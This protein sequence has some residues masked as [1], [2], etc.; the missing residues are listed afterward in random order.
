MCEALEVSASGYYAW[1]ARPDSPAEQWR[2]ELVAAIAAIHAE[3]K[4]RYGSPR[5]TA[6]LNT[7]GYGCSEYTVAR[8]MKAHDI[9]AKTP[10]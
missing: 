2:Q 9:R 4:Q 7:R 6:E 5:M 3:V 8:L 10:W 1:A